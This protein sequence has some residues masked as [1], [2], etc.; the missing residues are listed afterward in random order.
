MDSYILAI[1]NGQKKRTLGYL[2]QQWV[3][4]KEYPSMDGFFEVRF[5]GISEDEFRDLSLKLKQQGVTLIGADSAL[6]ENKIMKLT[7]LMNEQ[8]VMEGKELDI[9]EDLKHILKQWETKDY[10]SPEERFQEYFL[11]I[12]ELVEDYEEEVELNKHDVASDISSMNEQKLRRL[13]Q[14]LIRE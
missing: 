4:F 13:I 1:P 6:T 10:I 11:D 14:K 5:L 8:N 12:E 7:D 2:K 3:D 9:I